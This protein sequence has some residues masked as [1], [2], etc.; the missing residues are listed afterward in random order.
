MSE[1]SVCRWEMNREG[2]P[3]ADDTLDLDGAPVGSGDVLDDGQTESG[4]A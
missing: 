3:L 4:A 2:A 1:P